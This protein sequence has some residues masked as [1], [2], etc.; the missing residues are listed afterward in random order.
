[1]MN[2]PARQEFRHR[3][4]GGDRFELY[5]NQVFSV[6]RFWGVAMFGL[7]LGAVPV[8]LL[9]MIVT[10]P[11]EALF[12]AA[13]VDRI[14]AAGA[15]FWVFLSIPI[16]I[17]FSHRRWRQVQRNYMIV[18]SGGFEL[19]RYPG[20]PMRVPWTQVRRVSDPTDYTD[21]DYS[22][23]PLRFETQQGNFKLSGDHWPIGEIRSAVERYVPVT[24]RAGRPP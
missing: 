24:Y 6:I 12:G 14:G 11:L 19:L 5:G 7:A 2:E 17:Y 10:K 9:F 20:A 13:A 8:L 15:A 22:L 23:D 4:L 21:S 16:A 3:D 18:A 1:M